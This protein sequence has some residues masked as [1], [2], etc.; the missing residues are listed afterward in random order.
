M[1]L[2]F[3]SGLSRGFLTPFDDSLEKSTV[4]VRSLNTLVV[5]IM[6]LSTVSGPHTR[7]AL[8][9]NAAR[10]DGHSPDRTIGASTTLPR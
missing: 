1:T 10:R 2:S 5:P 6:A 4:L 9:F 3:C 8:Y 7:S